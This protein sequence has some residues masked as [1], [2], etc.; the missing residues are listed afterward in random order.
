MPFKLVSSWQV[1]ERIVSLLCSFSFLPFDPCVTRHESDIDLQ[2][3]RSLSLLLLLLLLCRE[4]G[5]QQRQR[6]LQLRL[7]QQFSGCSHPS[8]F[9]SHD[10]RRL[11]S[12]PLQTPVTLAA[13][14][15]FTPLHHLQRNI[16]A[17]LVCF[18]PIHNNSLSLRQGF[19]AQFMSAGFAVFT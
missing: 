15:C 10:H 18:G 16:M 9:Y 13:L 4:F 17:S 11:C 6:G 2:E 12:V 5:P 19:T 14:M 1:A 7:Q 8:A 3:R